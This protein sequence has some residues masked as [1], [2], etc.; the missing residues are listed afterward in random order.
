MN[1]VLDD[2]KM[3]CM[4]NSERIKF[5]NY[6]HMIFEVADLAV[7]SPATVSRCGMVYIDPED[8]GWMPYVKTW[9]GKFQERFGGIYTEYLMELFTKYVQAGLNF[10]TKKCTPAMVQVDAGKISALCSLIDSYLTIGKDVDLKLEETK[11][12][13]VICTTF[14]FCY[15]WAV[16]GNLKSTSWDAFDS[17]VRGQFEENPDAKLPGGGDLFSYYVDVK[18]RRMELWEKIV[19]KFVYNKEVPYFEIMVPTIDSTRYGY[20]MEKLLSTKRSVLFTGE[21]G[22]GKSVIARD[23]L[24]T[25]AEKGDYLPVFL[26]FSAQTSSTRVQEMIEAK[27]EKKRKNVL[28]AP[29]NKHMVIFIDDLNM[30]KLDRYFSQPPIELLRQYQD[31][32]GFYSR[33]EEGMPF[34]E[35][36]DMTISAACA[37]PGGGRNPVT[38]RLIRHFCMFNI[39][40]PNEYNLKHIFKA[41]TTGF[42]SD[43]N[44]AVKGCSDQIV[45]AAVE[46]YGR[47][48]AELLPTPA[49]SHYV[50]NLRDLSKCIQGMWYYFVFAILLYLILWL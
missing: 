2:N 31:F 4:A 44:F 1:T 47:M 35:I 41:I 13:S 27:L 50:F 43:F 30:P 12:K 36:K 10:A 22:V 38:L 11:L 42:F 17:F 14:A 37:P 21:T 16:G 46:I 18:N 25:V 40:A 26:N 7:A 9:I 8:L 49:K 48:S 24:L 33:T 20:L 32:G 29:K 19:P 3:L 6:M 15:V 34:V 23:L 39:P 45:E 28:G 5:T